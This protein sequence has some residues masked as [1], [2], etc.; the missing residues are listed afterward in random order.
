MSYDIYLNIKTGNGYVNVAGNLNITS[1]LFMMFNTAFGVDD[2]KMLDGMIAT[3]A[4]P[5]IR[6]AIKN[7]EDNPEIH[8]EHNPKN[9]WGDY[10]S[11]LNFLRK[12]LL[13]C[14]HHSLTVIQISY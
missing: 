6:K 10:Y 1:N 11:A 2:W 14:G 3:T 9:G 7:M 13:E 5:L 4:I 12:F 8:K